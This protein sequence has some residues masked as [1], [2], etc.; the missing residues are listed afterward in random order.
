MDTP[1]KGINDLDAELVICICIAGSALASWLRGP[2]FAVPS[3]TYVIEP[4]GAGGDQSEAPTQPSDSQA[5][6][7]VRKSSTTAAGDAIVA[8]E[9]E[10][11]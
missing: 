3:L 11:K 10:R 7:R 2:L 9:F 6:D 4:R 8:A 1:F 5:N